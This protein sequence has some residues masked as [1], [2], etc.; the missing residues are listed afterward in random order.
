MYLKKKTLSQIDKKLIT[1]AFQFPKYHKA[2]TRRT[3]DKL[4][5]M[6]TL[7]DNYGPIDINVDID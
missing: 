3:S 7:A 6:K 5:D 1:G 2:A 4:Y